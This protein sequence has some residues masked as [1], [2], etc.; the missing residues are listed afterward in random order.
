MKNYITIE[1]E[2]KNEIVINKSRFITSLKKTETEEEA[3]A[4]ITYIKDQY[5]GANHHCSA[6]TV[7]DSHQIQKAN[8]DGE[9]TGTAGVPILETLKKEE[10]HN[11]TAVVTRYFG[12]IKLGTG[13]LIRA[14]QSSVTQAVQLAGKV[15]IKAAVA[16]RIAMP[17]ELT[18]KFEHALLDTSYELIDTR[19]TDTVGY[20]LHVEAE[21]CEPFET[22]VMQ[23][24][25]G[26]AAIKKEASMMLPFTL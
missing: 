13:G 24:T 17:Y 14:Y 16:Y 8:D 20:I 23:M 19:Y 3:K 10:L 1:H 25:Q 12:G 22:F 18:G 7:G 15:H 4:F 6:Y 11:I 5:K 2:I 26:K 9:P 21:Q